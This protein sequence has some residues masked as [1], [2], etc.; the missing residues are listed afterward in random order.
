MKKIIFVKIHYLVGLI[1]ITLSSAC[2]KFLDER[3]SHS[4]KIPSS[5]SD[6]QALMDAEYVINLGGYPFL[7]E[8]WTDNYQIDTKNLNLM[9]DFEQNLYK[10]DSPDIY[11]PSNLGVWSN[12]Y[13][14][15]AISNI[16][17]ENIDKIDPGKSIEGRN[18]KGQALFL[19]A[20]GHFLLAQVFCL[21]YDKN[22][23]N[24]GL[25]IPLRHTSDANVISRRSSI[26]ETYD[27]I[28]NDMQEALKL[29][30]ENNGYPSRANK[31]AAYAA[32]SRIYLAM[33]WYVESEQAA[34][35][36]LKL[37]NS[38]MDLNEMTSLDSRLPYKINNV[39]TIFLAGSG[40]ALLR[41]SKGSLVTDELFE[42][43]EDNDLRRRSYFTKEKDG[44]YSF[45]GDYT[46]I[47]SGTIFCGL[48]TS[49]LLLDR[50]ECY[51]RIGEPA[52]A[53]AD[54]NLLLK[55]RIDIATFIPVTENDLN[56]LLKIIL[57]ERRKELINRSTRWQDLRRLNRDDRFKK[58]IVRTAIEN[59]VETEYKLLPESKFYV[60]KIPK[61]VIDLTGMPQN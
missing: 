11:P 22:S 46:G 7:I 25:G 43:F 17:L 16:V 26:K 44:G 40:S 27:D 10:F 32:L 38:L 35:E 48:T 23:D 3:T 54:L 8:A 59:G 28:L 51:A 18:I 45:K 36:A 56:Q 42:M 37:H 30:K 20:F 58:I 9:T 19:R 6:L 55:N 1:C 4:S 60:F 49:E 47:G 50:A 2:N 12:S 5:L 61:P 15:I 14:P 57:D 52:K 34:T 53:R 41:Q 13:K 31:A 24:G 29:L 33:E 39:E 21:P